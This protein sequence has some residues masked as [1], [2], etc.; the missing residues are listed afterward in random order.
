MQDYDI[1]EALEARIR[2]MCPG[3]AYVD[4]AWFSEPID[5]YNE[6]TPAALVY[7]V[8]DEGAPPSELSGRQAVTAVYGVFL[9]VEQGAVFREQR[10]AVR[11]AL[12]GWQPPGATG[13][14]AYHGGQMVELRGRYAWWRDFWRL[15]TP[16]A[17]VAERPRTMVI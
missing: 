12:F 17:L 14:M 8:E 10:N 1:T 2:E 6:Q 7:L 11:K 4:E 3:F 13:V 5:D 16:Q 15:E 9:I